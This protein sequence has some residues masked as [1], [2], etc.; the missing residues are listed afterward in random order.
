MKPTLQLRFTLYPIT[1]T[2]IVFPPMSNCIGDSVEG[3]W[4]CVTL[5]QLEWKRNI[6]A[7]QIDRLMFNS[8]V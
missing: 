8:W 3:L 1:L 4:P 2:I 5:V 7:C 6:Y